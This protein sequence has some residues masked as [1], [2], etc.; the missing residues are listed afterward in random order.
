MEPFQYQILE[1][2][3]FFRLTAWEKKYP[4]LVAGF[5]A[6]VKE[7]DNYQQNYALH[8][9]ENPEQVLDNRQKLSDAL[10]MS[11]SSWTCGEQVHGVSIQEAK[12]SDRGK[13]NRSRTDAFADTDGLLTDQENL[14]LAAYYAD[15]VP[16]Y[17]YSP[18]LEVVAVAHA[19][20]KGTVGK[21]G[22]NMIE[23]LVRRGAN[24]EQIEVAIGPS[25]GSCCYEVDENV[26]NP[27]RE[28]LSKDPSEE[29]AKPT[30]KSHWR[31]DLKLANRELFRLAEIPDRNILVTS[32]C[33]SCEDSFFYSHRRDH[34]DTGRM[35]A[36]IGK[37]NKS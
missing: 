2:I 3:P 14:L 10:G 12:A 19:G 5:S 34:G 20:W 28:A 33:T 29:I 30:D 27:L 25:I 35:V 8:V 36:L 26:I 21:I 1:G 22:P 11:L 17:F 6:R 16:L 7:R 13:G 24:R 4:H 23:E 31:L 32:Y 37:R 18:D 15:C 9:G